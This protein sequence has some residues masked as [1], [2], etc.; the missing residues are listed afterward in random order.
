MVGRL[1]QKFRAN[2]PLMKATSRGGMQKNAIEMS[3]AKR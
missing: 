2:R 3:T 1:G